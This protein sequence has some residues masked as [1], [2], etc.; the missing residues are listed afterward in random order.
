MATAFG[1][2]LLKQRSDQSPDR[3]TSALD[4]PSLCPWVEPHGNGARLGTKGMHLLPLQLAVCLERLALSWHL[5]PFP[6]FPSSP[7]AP[8]SCRS[9]WPS[10]VGRHLCTARRARSQAREVLPAPHAG[11]SLPLERPCV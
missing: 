3:V 10:S 4:E 6:R 8:G 1:V 7:L 9:F 5:L 2:Y 11:S